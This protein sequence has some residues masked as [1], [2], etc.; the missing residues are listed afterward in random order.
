[1]APRG[2]TQECEKCQ[3]TELSSGEGSSPSNGRKRGNAFVD[4]SEQLIVARL[5]PQCDELLPRS[6]PSDVPEE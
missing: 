3:S 5:S 4:P 6:R 1:M 2:T